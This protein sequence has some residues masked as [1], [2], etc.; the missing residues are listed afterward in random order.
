MN[1]PSLAAFLLLGL[2]LLTSAT[3][4]PSLDTLCNSDKTTDMQ[5]C[6]DQKA[7]LA[8]KTLNAT[9][10]QVVEVL[11]GKKR[12]DMVAALKSA[13]KTW[14][15]SRAADCRLYRT[16]YTNG[17]LGPLGYSFCMGDQANSRTKVLKTLLDE[18]SQ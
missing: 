13:E 3:T 10:Q 2:G 16:Y 4:R 11:T 9:Y 18:F 8:E 7:V 6:A 5:S 12:S 14:I 17:S 15:S 1:L